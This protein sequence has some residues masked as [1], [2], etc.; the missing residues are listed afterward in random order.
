MRPPDRR[1]TPRATGDRRH[2]SES[3]PTAWLVNIVG[4]DRLRCNVMT[5]QSHFT[6]SPSAPPEIYLVTAITRRNCGYRLRSPM[7]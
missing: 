3:R 6:S 1:V 4:A 2:Q 7:G 5:V